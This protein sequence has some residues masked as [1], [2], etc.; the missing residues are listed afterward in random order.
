MKA[1]ILAAG[2][3]TRLRPLTNNIPKCLVP[4]CGIPMVERQVQFLHEANITDITLVSGYKAEKLDYLKEKY[5]VRIVFNEKY[6]ECNNIYSMY[7][8]LDLLGDNYMIDGDTYLH[9]NPFL[10]KPTQ[11][12]Y[13]SAWHNEYVN[14]WG[15]AVDKDNHLTHI[16]IGK[17]KGYIMSGITY[18][19]QKDAAILKEKVQDAILHRDYKDLFWDN[20][21]VENCQL[22]DICVREFNHIFEID[23]ETELRELE[24]KIKLQQ[25]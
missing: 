23:K 8:V 15:L 6:N 18:W 11:S 24:N 4:V 7:K 19:T 25:L 10:K 20:I 9:T 17:V 16:E 21:V 2:L 3:G 14:E 12:T 5:N 22:M 1:I 13:W